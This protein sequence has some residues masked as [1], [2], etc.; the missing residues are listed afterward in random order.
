MISKREVGENTSIVLR[1]SIS[2]TIVL[3]SFTIVINDGEIC[4]SCHDNMYLR[5]YV[6]G[7][8]LMP[9]F[10]VASENEERL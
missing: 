9:E 5:Y 10:T 1:I 4:Y 3:M 7:D 6:Y 8:S 2:E